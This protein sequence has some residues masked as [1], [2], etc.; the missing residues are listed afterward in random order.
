[1]RDESGQNETEWQSVG[2]FVHAYGRLEKAVRLDICAAYLSPNI[3][4]QL[5][6]GRE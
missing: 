4:E 1:M 5:D 3:L 6:V 2:V